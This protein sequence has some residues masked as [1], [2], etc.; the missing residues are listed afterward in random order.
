MS[1][2]VRRKAANTYQHGDLR[3]ALIQAGLKLLTDGGVANLGLRAAAQLAGVSHTA[4]YRHFQDKN[5]LIDAIGERGFQMLTAR[6]RE[7]IAR[8]ATADA[9]ARLSASGVGYV[10]F[11]LQNPGYFRVIFSGLIAGDA[12]SPALHAAGEEAYGVLRGLVTE[13]VASGALV[14]KSIDTL[15]LCAWSLVHGLSMLA[16]DGKLSAWGEGQTLS[17]VVTRELL[18]LLTT[19][20]GRAGAAPVQRGTRRTSKS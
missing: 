13:G 7:E 3:E 18:A 11:A 15:S 1:I 19:G 9:L 10:R 16:I 17:D 20:I 5:A 8:V 4:P 2:R 14:T 12:V 6:M